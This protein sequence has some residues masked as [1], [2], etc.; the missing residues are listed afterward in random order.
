MEGDTI[1]GYMLLIEE[2]RVQN[3]VYICKCE[4]AMASRMIL[5]LFL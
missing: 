1:R 3:I 2:G 5:C 4:R